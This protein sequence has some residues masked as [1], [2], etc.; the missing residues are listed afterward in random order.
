MNDMASF[1]LSPLQKRLWSLHEEGYVYNNLL[2]VHLRGQLDQDK[3]CES[4]YHVIRQHESLRTGYEKAVNIRFPL[5]VVRNAAIPD[6][7][8]YDLRGEDEITRQMKTSSIIEKC[9]KECIGVSNA[10]ILEVILIREKHDEHLLL[11]K[12][13]A[14]ASDMTSML[15]IL[16]EVRACYEEEN[17]SGEPLQFIQ[18]SEWQ[19]DLIDNPEEEAKAFWDKKDYKDLAGFKLPFER[20]YPL[21]GKRIG[22]TDWTV[23]GELLSKLR[24]QADTLQTNVETLLLAC[25]HVTLS[26]YLDAGPDI[27]TGVVSMQRSFEDFTAINGPLNKTLPVQIHISRQLTMVELLR[28][29]E[30]EWSQVV[31][32][33]D[34]FVNTD[35]FFAGGFEYIPIKKNISSALWEVREAYTCSDWFK[36]KWSC[37][38][39]GDRL[40][41]NLYYLLSLFRSTDILHIRMRLMTVL[42]RMLADTSCTVEDLM[43]VGEA[44]RLH[45]QAFADT[46]SPYTPRTITDLFER[47]AA[48]TPHHLALGFQDKQYTYRQ[49]DEAA[50]RLARLLTRK[51]GDIRKK[52]VAFRMARSE[53]QVITMLGILKC[54][55]AYLP[56]DSHVPEER[57]KFMLED[58]QAVVLILDE[59]VDWLSADSM[60]RFPDDELEG[61]EP[62]QNGAGAVTDVAYLI[63]TSGSTGTPK[64]VLISHNALCNYLHWFRTSYGITPSDSTMLLSSV[65][66]DL[67]Y[68]SLWTS[69]T[70][71][72]A[73]HIFP[74]AGV[75]DPSSLVKELIGRRVTY[76][77]L[78]PSL[79]NTLVNDAGFEED[80]GKYHLRLVVLGGEEIN[81]KD[82]QRWLAVR[83][84]TVMVNHYGPTETTVGTITYTIDRHNRDAFIATPVIGRPIANSR[85]YII[86]EKQQLLPA[87]LTGEICIAGQGLGKGYLNNDELTRSRFIYCEEAGGDRVYRTGDLGRWTPD[88]CIQFLGRKD[89]QVKIRG[90]RIEPEEIKNV[91]LKIPVIQKAGVVTEGSEGD[92]QLI[93]Y[94]STSEEIPEKAI[95]DFLKKYLP[96]YMIPSRLISLQAFPLTEN[97][98]TDYKALAQHIQTRRG[99][100]KPPVTRTE[101]QVWEIW[102]DV[103]AKPDIGIDENFLEAGGH[104]LKAVQIVSRIVRALQVKIELKD[105]FGHP[106]IAAIS[107][108]IDQL[109]R[110]DY[111][112]ITAIEEQEH[113]QVSHAQKRLWIIDQLGAGKIVYNIPLTY[114]FEGPLDSGLLQRAFRALIC[115]HE[116]LRTS[117]IVVDGEPRQKI[118]T[119]GGLDFKI[120]YV[121]L[122][123]IAGQSEKVKLLADKEAVAP[124]DLTHAPLLRVTLLQLEEQYHVFM[125]TMHHI[126]SDAWSSEIM[127]QEIASFYRAGDV[128]GHP[129]SIQYKD[130]TVWQRRQLDGDDTRRHRKYW[131][132]Q[133]SGG[134]PR[135]SL[136]TDYPRPAVKTYNGDTVYHL[137]DRQQSTALKE[138]AGAKN[139]SLFMVLLTMVKILLYRYTGDEDIVIGSPVAGR[140]HADLEGQ[141]GFYLNNLALRTKIGRRDTFATLLERVREG[142]LNAYAHDIYP[143]DLL[144]DDLDISRDQSRSP[145]FDVVV[146]L[147]NIEVTDEDSTRLPEIKVSPFDVSYKV[148]TIDLRLVFYES[149]GNIACAIDYNTDL[150][151]KESIENFMKRFAIIVGQ[152]LDDADVR[153]TAYQLEETSEEKV[154]ILT[155]FNF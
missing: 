148:S 12:T 124:F 42:E 76:I 107:L 155:R 84:D 79:F 48:A 18:Y 68:T 145:L 62:L 28:A 35:V 10:A 126:I 114:Y 2:K 37:V 130:Y 118:M 66:F 97:G 54:G 44:E 52:I 104:S 15:N 19:H 95:R 85:V 67:C 83:A 50:G 65:A 33:Q 105:L 110:T 74:D 77:K 116:S 141:I 22:V 111:E 102:K 86:N 138:L 73:L 56:I 69:L 127:M 106:T 133:F 87:G 31:G 45:L 92:R 47:Q 63:Y 1:R 8:C 26:H 90:Y 70:S 98:K 25:W 112:A 123:G 136:P 20:E 40:T 152:T 119:A 122:R 134:I 23:R 80:A 147:R 7:A 43:A 75:F 144:V 58:S 96:D 151:K 6:I 72:S 49:L 64:G 146:M 150:F 91:L 13:P 132:D 89:F 39:F 140:N 36:L 41:C 30:A 24:E 100:K 81:T 142:A 117:F 149:R 143:F 137:I 53:K 93:A 113:Y 101:H 34:N 153:I 131:M 125:L 4:L 59:P 154:E 38:D 135:L 121:D 9:F 120:T 99:E 60:Y 129:L 78:T 103:L 51:Y 57:V 71:G 32:W 46:G 17:I 3:L 139:A 14:L 11:L 94:Y 115:R 109:S 21:E 108:F 29:L 55:A 82:L 128:E 88:G 16:E 5:Q 27:V 61:T